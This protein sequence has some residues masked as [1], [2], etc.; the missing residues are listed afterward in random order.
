MSFFSIY[1]FFFFFWHPVF[2][3]PLFVTVVPLCR[4]PPALCLPHRCGQPAA[5][6]SSPAPAASPFLAPRP[7]LRRRLSW[8]QPR[9]RLRR[10]LPAHAPT[11][12]GPPSSP[13]RPWPRLRHRLPVPGSCMRLN[14]KR[15]NLPIFQVELSGFW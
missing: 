8:P 13:P 2:S 3:R 5:S 4:P 7:H 10:R 12:P 6:S 14:G 1:C 11:L 9:P 15:R